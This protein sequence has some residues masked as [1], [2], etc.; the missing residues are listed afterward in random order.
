V[1][2]EDTKEIQLIC[3]VKVLRNQLDDAEIQLKKSMAGLSCPLGLLV[4]PDVLRVYMDR[5]TSD[6]PAQSVERIGEFDARPLFR[7]MYTAKKIESEPDF[8]AVVQHWLES[9]PQTFSSEHM[10]DKRLAAVLGTFI[11]PAI[12]TGSVSA[13]APRYV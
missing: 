3:E 6:N 9:L 7:H 13:A 4:T 5:Y 10:D 2:K 11:L 12:A 8:E 1:R